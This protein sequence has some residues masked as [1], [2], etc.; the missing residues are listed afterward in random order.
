[1]NRKAIEILYSKA[2]IDGRLGLASLDGGKTLVYG[3]AQ[4]EVC[5][6]RHLRRAVY[7]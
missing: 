7:L 2:P 3:E 1:M 6:R 4:G 5:R